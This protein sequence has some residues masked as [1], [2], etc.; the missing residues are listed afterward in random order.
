MEKNIIIRHAPPN[1][2]DHAPYGT[3]LKVIENDKTV[4]LYVQR[5]VKEDE[6]KWELIDSYDNKENS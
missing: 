5:S 4:L 3:E 2:Y 6:P 1:K